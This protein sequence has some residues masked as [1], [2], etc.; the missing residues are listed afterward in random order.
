M[1]QRLLR[2][3]TVKVS[4]ALQMAIME[5]AN[6]RKG[7]VTAESILL[8]LLEQKDSI[9]L[10]IF[11]ELRADTGKLRREI[12]DRVVAHAQELP[13]LNPQMAGSMQ[14]SEDVQNLFTASDAQRKKLGDSYIST[15]ALFLG[16]FDDEVPGS[17]RILSELEIDYEACLGALVALRGATKVDQKDS[18]SRQSMLEEYTT[19]ITA[20]ARRGVLDPV[21]G[22]GDEIR[23]TIE[24][25][26]RRKKNNPVLIGEPG[27]GKTVIVEGLAQQIVAADV[28][29]YLL[30]KRVLSLEMGTLIAG[31][32]MQGEFEE[33]LK[34]I[35]DEVV[36]SAGET[37]LFIDELHTV[38][39]TGRSGGG[40]DA[41]NMLK[42]ALAR[43]LLQCVGATTFK[44]YKQF[45]ESDKALERRFQ[46]VTIKQPSVDQTIE[47]LRGLQKK[48]E[49][50]HQIEYTDPAIVAAAELS[51]RYLTERF[52]PDKAIDLLDEAGASKR[53][54]VIYTPPELRK[55][56]TKRHELLN[57]K[58]QA[59]HQ[60]DFELMAKYQMELS[61]LEDEL[62]DSRLK[63]A[64][65]YS[66]E[67]R[68]VDEDNI[69]TIVSRSTGIPVQKMMAEEAEKLGALEERLSARVIGQENAAKSVANAIR[70]NRSGLRQASRP[71][72]SFLFLG[73][74]GVGKTEMVK[75]IAAELMGDESKIVRVDM[76]E[77][78]ERHTVSR[79]IGSPPGY[80]GYGEGGQL[81]EQVRRQP[82]SVVLLDEFE[83]AHPDV[84]NVMLQVLDEGWL[85]DA[86]GR[87][88][89][90]RNCV[91]IGT[92]N[93]G[94]E[95]LTDR[96]RP[97]G[98]GAQNEEWNSDEEQAAVMG[99]VKRYLRPEFINRLDEII[100]FNRL[101]RD[102]LNQILDLQLEDLKER[103]KA[104]GLSLIFDA[105]AR[106][107]IIEGIDSLNYG[108]RP[109]RRK[110]EQLVENKIA[111]FLIRP[112]PF[113]EG[114]LRIGVA[115]GE[116]TVTHSD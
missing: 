10:K 59:F 15:G 109:L 108:A 55:L 110:L 79:L 70:R 34:K 16:C 42:P 95:I 18:E 53:L 87:R 14:V 58:S 68:R 105:A 19:D 45:I 23:R 1:P 47:I 51:D 26:S 33:R 37:I 93:L 30:N 113:T 39:G 3:S 52:L 77:Y 78:M 90:F 2:N 91:I 56:E 63:C 54:K 57:K 88:V 69:A 112:D 98:I 50:H 12:A 103:L 4:E 72:A 13:D 114:S 62:K 60:Q 65:R 67:E 111:N 35:V 89:S 92:S 107:L 22:R 41:S 83:K 8:A 48:Y 115:Q 73:P 74:T 38:V 20:M 102:D 36:A 27:V 24:I 5:L 100:V 71:V 85:T 66:D 96:K 99:E 61:R 81:T 7:V 82:Y 116:I 6:M 94:S 86:E 17:K 11:D 64:D 76:S 104:T 9:V 84:Y 40:L 75:T 21:I 29:E 101:S 32:K 43:G 44:E 106:D 28:P 97:V 49:E 25:L 80:V 31:A 46:P